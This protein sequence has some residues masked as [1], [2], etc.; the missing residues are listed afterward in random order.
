MGICEFGTV[1]AGRVPPRSRS[2][3]EREEPAVTHPILDVVSEDP[4]IQHVAGHVQEAARAGTSDVITDG[5][6]KERRDQTVRV[7]EVVDVVASES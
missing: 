4:E 5:H 3:I 6:E 2:E 1:K 7:H